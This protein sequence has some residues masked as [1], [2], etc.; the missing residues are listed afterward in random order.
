MSR[1]GSRIVPVVIG[2]AT[3]T[4]LGGNVI[5]KTKKYKWLTVFGICCSITCFTFMCVRWHGQTNWPEACAVYLAGFGMGTSQSTTFV[6][7]A[8]SLDHSDIAIAG[9]T[10]FLAQSSGSLIGASFDISLMNAVLRS[11][12]DRGLN[13]I[14]N[15]T[16]VC[17]ISAAEA[18]QNCKKENLTDQPSFFRS[19]KVLPRAS[20]PFELFHIISNKLFPKRISTACCTQMVRIEPIGYSI[21]CLGVDEIC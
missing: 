10:W 2:N 9:T 8:A 18:K 3:G 13:G 21:Y 1:A 17:L 4:I 12:L 15:K 6:H 20:N 19:S 16:Q 11:D 7:L 14:E 5:S